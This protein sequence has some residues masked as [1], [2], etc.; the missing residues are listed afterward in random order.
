M[1][2]I[3]ENFTSPIETAC[4]C[5]CGQDIIKPELVSTI[6]A[7]RNLAG[8]SVIVHCW[9][10][11]QKHNDSLPNSVPNSQHIYGNAIDFHVRGMSMK[12]LHEFIGQ[13]YEDGIIRHVGYYDWGCHIDIRDG[14]G[15]WGEPV[16]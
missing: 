11:C 8:N 1:K 6:Q 14:H 2:K 5:G 10:R 15:S 16:A 9:N 7:I 12:K 3:S 4:K 13:L